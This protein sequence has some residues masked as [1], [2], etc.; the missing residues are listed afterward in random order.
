MDQL[1]ESKMKQYIDLCNRILNEGVLVTNKRTNEKCL[2]VID[3]SMEYD[4]TD[5]KLPILTTKKVAWKVAIAEMLGYLRGYTS[6]AQFRNIGCNTWNA[7]ANKTKAWLNNPNRKGKD[8]MGKVY[9]AV[10]RDFGG[11]DLVTEA[12]LKIKARNDDRDITITFYK[13]DEFS[14][15]CLRPCMHTHTFSILDDT[16]YLTSYQ[17]SVDVAL[18]LPFNMVQSSWLL[19][20]MADLTNLKPGKV[21]HKMVNVHIYEKH[22]EAIKEQIKREP[23]ES[24]K[25]I[26]N[27][28]LINLERVLE[29]MIVELDND[30]VGYNP[31]PAIKYEFTP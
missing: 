12:Y 5:S 8:D 4:C 30:V 14:K 17:R 25:L 3:A 31:H 23:K 2:T 27:P 24:P 1:G 11:I 9:G 21:F 13:P 16:L 6:A 28:A 10:A 15:G 7:N 22:I 29:Y 20:L 18:G 19:L 26:I